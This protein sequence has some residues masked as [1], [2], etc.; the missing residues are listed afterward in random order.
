MSLGRVMADKGP[1]WDAIV[2]KHQLQPYKLEQLVPSFEYA[3]FTFRYRQ[4][5]FESLQST[6]KI[7]QAGFH[8]CID[9]QEM[10]VNRFAICKRQEYCLSDS[11]TR[12]GSTSARPV[13]T[14]P[15]DNPS[16]SPAHSRKM[17]GD[18]LACCVPAFISRKQ[19]C[20]AL[21]AAQFPR[22]SDRRTRKFPQP[23]SSRS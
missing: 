9:T 8:D 19:R 6:I 14:L 3:D 1:I 22:R 7:R 2:K 21:G 13:H 5:P 12:Y 11:V 15:S 18:T 4:T 23:R 10:F 16:S 17:F 20:S